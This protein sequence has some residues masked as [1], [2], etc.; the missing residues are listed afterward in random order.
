VIRVVGKAFYDAEHAGKKPT[1]RRE[2]QTKLAVW[3]IHPV[4]ELKVLT[5]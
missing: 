3:E 4:M 5:E 2:K 1:N